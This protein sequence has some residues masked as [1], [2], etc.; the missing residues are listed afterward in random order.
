MTGAQVRQLV[1]RHQRECTTNIGR[2]SF[3]GTLRNIRN[4]R[5]QLHTPESERPDPRRIGVFRNLRSIPKMG[6]GWNALS[7]RAKRDAIS[8]FLF[9]SRDEGI[10][11]GAEGCPWKFSRSFDI[12]DDFFGEGAGEIAR[13]RARSMRWHA[14]CRT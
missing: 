6:G 10:N 11:V 12:W 5:A 3:L 1:S 4:E 2:A 8:V 14:K 7:F 9:Q 13:M